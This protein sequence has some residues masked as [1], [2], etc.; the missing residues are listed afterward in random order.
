MNWERDGKC[1]EVERNL[2]ASGHGGRQE[3][4]QGE[5]FAYHSDDFSLFLSFLYIDLWNSISVESVEVGSD[6]LQLSK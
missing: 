6:R 3:D 5:S 4:C 2:S 1:T